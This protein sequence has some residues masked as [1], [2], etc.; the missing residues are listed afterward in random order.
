MRDALVNFGYNANVRIMVAPHV[1]GS[2][3]GHKGDSTARQ[4]LDEI[5]KENDLDWYFDGAVIYVSPSSE[6]QTEIVPLNGF[7]FNVMKKELEQ[8]R[9]FDLRYRMS[10]Q[11]G[12]DAA[13]LSGPP[14]FVTIMKQAIESRAGDGRISTAEASQDL[15]V[16]RGSQS[17]TMKVR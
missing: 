14:S 13:I 1:I 10:R 3:Q 6:E 9:I 2:V 17:S 4:F 5:T 7:P 12:S 15:V 11:I 8:Q 16:L